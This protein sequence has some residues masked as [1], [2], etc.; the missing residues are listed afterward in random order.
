MV[1]IADSSPL[2]ALTNIDCT[3]VLPKLFREI[4]I[5]PAVAT[6]LALPPRPKPVRDFIARPPSWLKM[7]KPSSLLP[8][9]QLHP[10]EI[11]ALSLA[12]ELHA[13]LVLIDERK[14]Y[15]EALARKLN[16]VGTV[17]VLERAAEENLID[18]SVA[19]N[20]LK[21]TDFWISTQLLDERLR[22]FSNRPKK[23]KEK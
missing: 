14:A 19:F 5:P 20:N 9:P 21:K 4:V 12:L 6:E 11:E 2:I 16:A 8:I 7:V 10:G 17:R 23:A 18:L 1:V 15:R 13:D 22:L 3:E